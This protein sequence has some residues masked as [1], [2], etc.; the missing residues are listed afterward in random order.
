MAARPL[1]LTTHDRG[2][3]A[4]GRAFYALLIFSI[5]IGFLT[6]GALL[7]DVFSRAINWTGATVD[8]VLLLEAPSADPAV[9]G[10]RPAILA[11][12]YLGVLLILFTVPIGVGTAIY[13]EEYANRERWYNR[14]LEINIQNLAAVP[15]I[16]YGILGLAF[17]VRGI[18]LGRVLLAGAL[19]L[20]L[21]VL[22]TVIIA[23]REA[24]R[25]VPGSIRQGAY[26][27]G[28][29]QWQ[30]IWR[31][32]LPAA[33]PGMATGTILALSRGLGET[34]P[35]ILVGALTYVSFNPTLLGDFTALP[36]QIFQ[37]IA[38]P[39]EEFRGPLAAAG[40][41]VLLVILLTLNAAA[42]WIRNR[43]QRRW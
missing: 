32:V 6:L 25:A 21:L 14:L 39:Q 43:Y 33:A 15:S 19:I 29:T 40:I 37:W 12:I 8:L 23:S 2:A 20:T 36:I 18:G 31:Q 35:L 10:A 13:L 17:L 30:V 4:R 41:V 11:T 24:I 5:A 3:E 27:L 16:V 9:A 22:P 38:R 34:A 42:I 1:D 28:A 7:V 26:A